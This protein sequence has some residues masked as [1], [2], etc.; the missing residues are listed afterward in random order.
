MAQPAYST[1]FILARSTA[2]GQTFTWTCPAGR[3]AVVRQLTMNN[4]AAA[5]ATVF[6]AVAGI[7]VF[8]YELPASPATRTDETRLTVY[9]GEPVTVQ[10]NSTDLRISVDGFLYTDLAASYLEQHGFERPGEPQG[11]PDLVYGESL[12]AATS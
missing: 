4:A 9:S 3:R 1:R 12:P 10:L 2:S 6:I 11:P 5:A 7:Y 8:R